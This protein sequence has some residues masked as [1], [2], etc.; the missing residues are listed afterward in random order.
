MWTV[1]IPMEQSRWKSGQHARLKPFLFGPIVKQLGG[2]GVY[3]M[4]RS[5]GA[6]LKELMESLYKLL[7]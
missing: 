6:D 3:H 4:Y 5:T 7:N 1:R 2:E